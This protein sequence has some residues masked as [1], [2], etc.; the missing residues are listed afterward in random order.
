MSDCP[1]TITIQY[2]AL[3][4]DQ[5]PTPVELSA[6]AVV[7]TEDNMAVRIYRQLG[8]AAIRIGTVKRHGGDCQAIEWHDVPYQVLDWHTADEYDR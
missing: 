2:M 6:I 4:E 7:E 1:R 5:T 8:S 3:L